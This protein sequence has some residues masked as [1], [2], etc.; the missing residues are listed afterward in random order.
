MNF[1][2]SKPDG[3]AGVSAPLNE[4]ETF[5][6][7]FLRLADSEMLAD[8]EFVVGPQ[9]TVIKG[10]KVFF[11]A[12][13]DV[14]HAMFLGALKE[15]KAV[16]VE[17][18]EPDGFQGMKKYIYTG[19]TDFKS[20]FEALASYVAARKYLIEPLKK[21]CGKHIR[22]KVI[23]LDINK[24]DEFSECC[25]VNSV[26]IFDVIISNHI[27]KLVAD[28]E[29]AEY[30]LREWLP[31]SQIEIIEFMVKASILKLK[32]EIEVFC[33][34]ERW[35]LAEAERREIREEDIAT[36]F[37]SLKK[38]I[39]FLTMSMEDFEARVKPSPL[40]TSEE[41][42]VIAKNIIK[43]DPNLTSENISM[44]KEHRKFVTDPIQS[45]YV[46]R[47]RYYYNNSG[48]RW[49]SLKLSTSSLR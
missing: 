10:H 18:L 45:H 4:T 19:E 11:C 43:F 34:F 35:A 42:S 36:S 25:K 9:K 40:L 32:S 33:H 16:H 48:W 47:G 30:V 37:N 5:R 15:T 17:D 31:S 7:R 24:V 39:R 22:D 1:L 46:D 49:S 38:H 3:I 28:P 26:S 20:V 41:K 8:C 2:R 27:K 13:S 21:V 23:L 14:F 6:N 12:A 44:L 29:N